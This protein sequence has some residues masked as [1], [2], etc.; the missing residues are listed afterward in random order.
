MGAVAA[1]NVGR[2]ARLGRAIR[3]LQSG[4]HTTRALLEHQELRLPLDLDAGVAK[5]IDQ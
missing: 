3:P 1:G 2:L 5:T 4:A